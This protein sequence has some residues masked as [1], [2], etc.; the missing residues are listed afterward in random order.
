MSRIPVRP[1]TQGEP[2][3]RE[4]ILNVLTLNRPEQAESD[5][6]GSGIGRDLPD[7]RNL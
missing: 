7:P 3:F 5:A 6:A 4:D 1:D 2:G